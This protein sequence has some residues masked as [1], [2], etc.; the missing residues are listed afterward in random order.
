MR[1][2]II[3]YLSTRPDLKYFMREQ[4]NWYRELTRNPASIEK[5][6]EDAK[7]FFGRTFGQRID[8]FHQQVKGLS[9]LLDFIGMMG[10]NG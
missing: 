8:R 6:E 7:V 5:L 2:E 9:L 10:E 1:R 3:E 4:P